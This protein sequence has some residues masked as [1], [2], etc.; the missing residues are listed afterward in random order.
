[1]KK[2]LKIDLKRILHSRRFCILILVEI[3]VVVLSYVW[4]TYPYGQTLW[5]VAK[6]PFA[7]APEFHV[8]WL[9]AY[10]PFTWYDKWIG[11]GMGDSILDHFYFIAMPLCAAF[12]MGD[13]V[14]KDHTTGYV[15]QV[16]LH[17]GRKQYYA[18]KGVCS[19]LVGGIT[20]LIPLIVNIFLNAAQFSSLVPMVE[21]GPGAVV[22]GHVFSRLYYSHPFIYILIYLFNSFMYGGAFSVLACAVGIFVSNAFIPLLFPFLVYLFQNSLMTALQHPEFAFDALITMNRAYISSYL[23]CLLGALC[24]LVPGILGLVYAGRNDETIG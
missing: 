12:A 4:N 23:F 7:A 24:I 10:Y 11:A 9:E 21:G 2:L 3:A 13:Y 14:T 6:Q 8:S 17:V 18:E 20:I 15:K 5:N 16:F 22:H 1:M 19:F